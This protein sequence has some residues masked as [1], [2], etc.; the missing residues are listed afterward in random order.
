MTTQ[1]YKVGD[2]VLVRA[3]ISG[4]VDD[5]YYLDG[6]YQIYH[7]EKDIYSLAPEFNYGEEIEVSDDQINWRRLE[8][9][10][11]LNNMPIP[12]LFIVN[13]EDKILHIYRYARK[14][15]RKQDENILM[16]EGKKYKL[17]E[18]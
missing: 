3:K 1:K 8:F 15:Q 5:K 2:E 16:F 10:S 12:K 6:S 17:V 9:V 4:M 18:E 14:I 11:Y 13:Q 7:L